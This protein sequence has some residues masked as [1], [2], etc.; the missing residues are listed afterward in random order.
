ML[1]FGSEKFLKRDEAYWVELGL[2]VD[3]GAGF[4]AGEEMPKLMRKKRK[5]LRRESTRLMARPFRRLF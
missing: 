3:L 4:L 5:P 2:G 1:L